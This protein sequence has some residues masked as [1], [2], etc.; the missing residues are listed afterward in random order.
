MASAPRHGPSV[1]SSRGSRAADRR[2]TSGGFVTSTENAESVGGPSR[3]ALRA[4]CST[5]T[6]PT[7]TR[8]RGY[9]GPTACRAAGITYRQLD[10]WARTGLVEPS[11]RPAT[12]LRHAAPVQLPRHPRAQGGQAAARHGRL[13]AADPHRGEPPARARGRRPRADH[14]HVRRCQRLRVHLGRRGH[15]PGPGRPGRVRH[16]RRSRVARGRGHPRRAAD[17]ARRRGRRG[18]R[19]PSPHDELAM[20]RQ[21]RTAG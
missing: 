2:A 14:P 8:R 15:R 16:R 6:S 7:S 21:A 3:S 17:R 19:E 4:C 13:A 9:R 1:A 18:A 12:G 10:Y 11:I 20:R 5:T